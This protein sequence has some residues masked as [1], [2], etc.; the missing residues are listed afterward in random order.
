MLPQTQGEVNIAGENVSLKMNTKNVEFMG[1]KQ[2]QL[3][4]CVEVNSD[5]PTSN[6]GR[7][8][9]LPLSP[10]PKTQGTTDSKDEKD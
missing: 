5:W 8:K 6:S 4:S 3:I 10:S 7:G 2:S 1:H 9:L